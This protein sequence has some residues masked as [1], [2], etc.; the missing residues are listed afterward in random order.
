VRTRKTPKWKIAII[1]M[2]S[3]IILMYL[4]VTVFYAWYKTDKLGMIA[5]LSKSSFVKNILSNTQYAKDYEKNVQNQD[6]DENS[7]SVNEGLTGNVETYRNIA[8]FGIDSRGS[9]FDEQTHSDTIIVVSINNKTGEVKMAS[10][11]RDTMLK[12]VDS[13]GDVSYTKAN[14]AFYKGGPECAINMLNTNL[15]LNIQDYVV[16]NFTGLIRIIDALGGIDVNITQEEMTLINGYMTE[17]RLIT[18][19]DSPNLTSA[20]NVHLTGLQATAFC[21]IRY[22]A[23]TDEDGTVYNNDFGRTARQRFVIRQLVSKA[24]AAGATQVMEI[25]NTVLNYNTADEKVIS[26]SLSLT[27]IMDLIPTM[28]G[29]EITGSEGFPYTVS[30]PTING[31]SMVVAQG[32]SYNVSRLHKFLFNETSYTPSDTVETISDYLISYT[33]IPTVK[34]EEDQYEEQFGD[35]SENSTDS[36]DTSSYDADSDSSYSVN[37]DSDSNDSGSTG[38]STYGTS[39]SANNSYSDDDYSAAS[40]Y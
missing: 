24:K 2:E 23:F 5:T 4:I 39:N 16:V 21:R 14:A 20:G 15:D 27:E 17:T 33:G 10:V 28:I 38:Y 32:L 35:V 3:F 30:T 1:V 7:I 9:E 29:F 36:D 34:L 37:D 6:F 18:G 19:L 22:V 40:G 25:V 11:Y 31:A 12:I 13:D 8:L 26:T